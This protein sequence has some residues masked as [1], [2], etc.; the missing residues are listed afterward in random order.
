[1]AYKG[2]HIPVS[3]IPGFLD[4]ELVRQLVTQGTKVVVVGNLIEGVDLTF[5]RKQE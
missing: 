5:H 3:G 2:K 4:T 1:M